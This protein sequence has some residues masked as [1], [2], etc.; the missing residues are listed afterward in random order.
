MKQNLGSPNAKARGQVQTGLTA[1]PPGFNVERAAATIAVE[2]MVALHVRTIPAGLSI[3]IH[4]LDQTAFHQRIE[5]VVNGR[6]RNVRHCGLR[7]QEHF[8]GAGMIPLQK[9]DVIDLTALRRQPQP[10][11]RK[12]LVEPRARK[13]DGHPLLHHGPP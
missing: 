10:G 13:I 5:T 7:P 12:L 8:F 3:M 4:L 1:R 6:H 9:Q 11:A 2:V